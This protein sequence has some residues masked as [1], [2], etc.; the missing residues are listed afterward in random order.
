M[1]QNIYP[2]IN[3]SDILRIKNFGNN[4]SPDYQIPKRI[5]GKTGEQLS[6]IGFGGIMLNDN[7]QDFANEIV[8]KA[9]EL[10]VNYFD[11]SPR[12]GNSENRLGPAL[13][14]S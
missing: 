8:T 12:Y 11:V 10:G 3:K 4:F 9:F 2:P 7:S 13:I 1:R 5:L 14:V 6:I